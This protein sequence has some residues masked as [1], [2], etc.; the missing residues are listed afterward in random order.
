MKSQKHAKASFFA[1]LGLFP[2]SLVRVTRVRSRLRHV[3]HLTL[4]RPAAMLLLASL[5]FMVSCDS[6]LD[7]EPVDRIDAPSFFS[8]DQELLIGMTGAYAAQRAIYGSGSVYNIIEG[9]SD[10]AGLDH[11]D[12]EERV[13]TDIFTEV[14]G[15]LLLDI[16]WASMYNAINLA[17]T[18][19]VRGPEASGDAA[20]IERV[21]GE[22]KFI[23]AFTYLHMVNLWGGV[24]LRTTPTEDFEN[25]AIPRS[26]PDEVYDLIVK[27]LTEA[28]SVLPA[29]YSG[30][31]GEEVG[32]VTR[33]AALTLLGKAE[34]Q[35]GNA[36]AAMAA[37]RQVEG[38]YLL[39]SDY[40]AI[41]GAGN[42]N[43]AESIFEINFN[44]GNQ[45]GLFRGGFIPQSVASELGIVAGGSTRAILFPFATQDLVDAFDDPND[46]RI[47][48]T[49]GTAPG[50]EPGGY[51]SKFI[52]LNAA[53]D[54]ANINLVLL[55]YADVLLSLAEALGEGGEAYA[56]INQVRARAGL[57]G[58]DVNTPG[59]FMEKLMKERRLEFAFEIHRWFDLLRLPQSETV[60]VMNAQLNAQQAF[61]TQSSN[62]NGPTNFNL[63]PDRLLYP[64]PQLEIDI[65]GGAVTQNPGH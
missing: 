35:R 32:R 48:Y 15:N 8:T 4:M 21:V 29:S 22:A 58:I 41:H 62:Y 26:S 7:V 57:P 59:T 37:L 38:Q 11:T 13:A 24:P 20:L 40:G 63:T 47:P 6:F 18:V 3:G 16:T 30:G 23:R 39:L 65:S 53:T 61:F 17:N 44:T 54:G 27:D 60:A 52:D 28:I 55:R 33:F 56:L 12:Q 49:Y 14:P 9:R 43:T 10:N 1:H 50:V 5:L 45:T 51:I 46:L 19:I 64:I 42:D 2:M 31:A 34:L 25:F 36:S